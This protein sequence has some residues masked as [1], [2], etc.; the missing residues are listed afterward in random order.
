[1]SF[2]LSDLD[3]EAGLRCRSFNCI[4]CRDFSVNKEK[5]VSKTSGMTFGEA[6]EHIKQGPTYKVQRKGWNGK[7][8]WISV[9]TPDEHS[10][11]RRPY[12]YMYP[13]DGELVPWLAS[14]SDM[15]ENDWQMVI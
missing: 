3:R 14:Q 12:I 10:K 2:N 6:L 9:Q 8:M 13:V 1:M 4:W 15:L 11:M 7:G 5:Q